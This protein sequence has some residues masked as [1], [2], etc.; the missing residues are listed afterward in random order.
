MER[1]L[2]L[3]A[4]YAAMQAVFWMTVCVSLTF[5]AVYLQGLGYSNT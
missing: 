5:A 1:N 4:P 2:S 3:T